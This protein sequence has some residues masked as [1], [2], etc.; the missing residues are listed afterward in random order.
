MRTLFVA[1]GLLGLFL[2]TA[3]SAGDEAERFRQRGWAD[4]DFNRLAVP[5]A[6]IMSGGPPKDGIPSIDAPKFVTIAG[7]G[8]LAQREPVIALV[9]NGDARAYPLQVLTWHEIVND[10][11]GGVPVTVTYCPLCNAAIVFERTVE[12]KV[13]DFGTTGLLRNSDLVMYDR[14]SQSWWQQ[15]TGEAIV[16]EMTGMTLKTVPARL[17][18]FA[19]FKSEHP[20]GR[21]LVPA[22]PGFRDYGRN[23]YGGYDT[24]AQPFLYRGEMPKGMSPM[25]RVVVVRAAGA[26]RAYA[27][28]LLAARGRIVDGDLIITWTSGQASAL[29]ASR[30]ADGRD[31]GNIRVQRQSAQG[32]EDVAYDVTFAFVVTAFYPQIAIMK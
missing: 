7:A 1:M 18:S 5:L 6:E 2:A 29:D 19:L 17:Q 21:V 13:L 31:V 9:L 12:G 20:D 4:T 10:I 26:P 25:A 14:Q 27:L 32:L 28:E 16:G 8:H 15:F 30:I 22:D 23:P 24:A 11:V 3:A